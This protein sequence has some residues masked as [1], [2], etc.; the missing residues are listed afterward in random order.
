M[1]SFQNSAEGRLDLE[2]GL[3]IMPE[4]VNVRDY[5]A[6]FRSGYSWHNRW[7]RIDPVLV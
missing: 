6:Y 2:L 7:S 5:M 4:M 3:E 1:Y